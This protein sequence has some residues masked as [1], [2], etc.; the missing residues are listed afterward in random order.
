[1]A[2]GLALARAQSRIAWLMAAHSL[3]FW[4]SSANEASD[5]PAYWC[6]NWLL[7]ILV[8]ISKADNGFLLWFILSK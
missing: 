3:F 8:L 1:M 2:A 5:F 6:K 4:S 7:L